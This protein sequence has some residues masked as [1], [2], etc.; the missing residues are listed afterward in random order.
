MLILTRRVGES[1]RIGDT[2]RLTILSKLRAHLTV[3]LSVPPHVTIT[4]DTDTTVSPVRK[5]HRRGKRYL[6]AVMVGDSL[7]IG[8]EVVVSFGGRPFGGWLGLARGRQ[9]RI[10]IDAPRAIPVHREE[11]YRRIQRGE[12]DPRRERH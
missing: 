9:V 10:D 12:P 5:R 2:V 7:R 3:A 11:V 4:D 8:E 1:I 6:I